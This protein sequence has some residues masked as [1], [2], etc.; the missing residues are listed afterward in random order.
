MPQKCELMECLIYAARAHN[1]ECHMPI[2]QQDNNII[3]SNTVRARRELHLMATVDPSR[4]VTRRPTCLLCLQVIKAKE[5]LVFHNSSVQPSCYSVL[6]E[7]LCEFDPASTT[8]VLHAEVSICRS[9]GRNLEKFQR[10]RKDFP[11]PVGRLT[12]TSLPLKKC[13][14]TSCLDLISE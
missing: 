9:C 14:T 4:P 2:G 5:R 1:V 6:E 3:I 11:L 12:K 10:L 13:P 7:F 8:V